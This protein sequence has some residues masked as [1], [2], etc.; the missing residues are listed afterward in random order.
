LASSVK[1][2]P[3]SPA[4]NFLAGRAGAR[5]SPLSFSDGFFLP[6][7]AKNSSVSLKYFDGLGLKKMPAIKTLREEYAPMLEEKKPAGNT[8]RPSLKCGNY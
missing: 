4:G 6:A 7:R 1:T 3:V 2:A 5:I 8:G